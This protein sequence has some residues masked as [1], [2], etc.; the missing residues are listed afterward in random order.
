MKIIDLKIP[1][2]IFRETKDGY[3]NIHHVI[4]RNGVDL[5]CDKSLYSSADKSIFRFIKKEVIYQNRIR[6]FKPLLN[7][8]NSLKKELIM[9]LFT[10]DLIK[11]IS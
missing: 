1:S 2:W 6:L 5:Y 10:M 11:S 7:M 9:G 8:R 3:I 4:Y